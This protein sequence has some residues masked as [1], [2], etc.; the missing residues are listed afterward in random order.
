MNEDK[1]MTDDRKTEGEPIAC[2]SVNEVVINGRI[3]RIQEAKNNYYYVYVKTISCQKE[4]IVKVSYQSETPLPYRYRDR[5]VVKGALVNYRIKQPNGDYKIGQSIKAQSIKPEITYTEKRFGIPGKFLQ[6]MSMKLYLAGTVIGYRHSNGWFQYCIE[7]IDPCSGFA[8]T[9][10]AELRDLDRHPYIRKGDFVYLVCG[11]NVT[12]RTNR[13]PPTRYE[14]VIISD[15]AV[16]NPE[17]YRVVQTVLKENIDS[18]YND[19]VRSV[20][21]HRAETASRDNVPVEPEPE[22][23]PERIYRETG[24]EAEGTAVA[25]EDDDDFF[26]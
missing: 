19:D 4:I 7:T 2:T 22:K 10:H 23:E 17:G 16:I 1:I 26:F 9:V 6:S 20:Y 12:N 21:I 5:V 24:E 11:Y 3:D 14:D 13:V 25:P 15:I 18:V 8:V